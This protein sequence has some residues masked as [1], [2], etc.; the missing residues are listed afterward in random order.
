MKKSCTRQCFSVVGS[1]CAIIYSCHEIPN[2]PNLYY[3]KVC[4]TKGTSLLQQIVLLTDISK[5]EEI[6]NP[7]SFGTCLL[8]AS[9][10]H[11]KYVEEVQWHVL[12]CI[13]Y[14]YLI[15]ECII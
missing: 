8:V 13:Q 2:F 10:V 11:V 14:K 12:Y 9:G 6:R 5:K 1:L 15:C 3:E 4:L 7:I